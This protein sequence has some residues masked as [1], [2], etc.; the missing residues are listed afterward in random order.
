MT[1]FVLVFFA[2]DELLADIY[3]ELSNLSTLFYFFNIYLFILA[4][5]GM[6]AACRLS[7]VAEHGLL[8]PMTS[9]V[10]KHGL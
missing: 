1:A 3:I 6:V 8:I 4:A 5:L 9:L 2:W 7:L 10:V